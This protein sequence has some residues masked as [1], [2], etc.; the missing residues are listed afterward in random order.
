[1]ELLD[2]ADETGEERCPY[3]EKVS[4]QAYLKKIETFQINKLTRHL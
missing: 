1:M 4:S 2:E 3:L